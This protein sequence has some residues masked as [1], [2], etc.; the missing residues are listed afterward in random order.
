MKWSCTICNIVLGN[1]S[2]AA[3]HQREAHPNRTNEKYMWGCDECRS[4]YFDDVTD[5]AIHESQCCGD[6]LYHDGK[7]IDPILLHD[8]VGKLQNPNSDLQAIKYSTANSREL[9]SALCKRFKDNHFVLEEEIEALGMQIGKHRQIR[10]LVIS[11]ETNFKPDG[12]VDRFYEEM[13]SSKSI[14]YIHFFHCELEPEYVETL[15]SM[16]NLV[17]ITMHHCKLLGNFEEVIHA[18]VNLQCIE[19]KVCGFFD[20]RGR[21]VFDSWMLG[22]FEESTSLQRVTFKGCKISEGVKKEL[23]RSSNVVVKIVN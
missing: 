3:K 21:E 2:S 8:A 7:V 18:T 16:D 23:M 22:A 12:A 17:K 5:A 10:H 19:F 9:E 20:W 13:G 15:L 1:K 14:R 6:K 11:G 4:A